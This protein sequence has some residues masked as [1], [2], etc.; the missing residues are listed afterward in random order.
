MISPLAL[1]STPI[2]QGRCEGNEG[3][4]GHPSLLPKLGGTRSTS[5]SSPNVPS[6]VRT[7]KRMS[8]KIVSGQWMSGRTFPA[9]EALR[10]EGGVDLPMCTQLTI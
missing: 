10:L 6:I 5:A 8:M 2:L 9:P 7:L 1:Q 4:G 3:S